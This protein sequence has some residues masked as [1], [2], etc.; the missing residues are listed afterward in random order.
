VAESPLARGRFTETL[1]HLPDVSPHAFEV[2]GVLDRQ[3]ADS[4]PFEVG[5]QTR[6]TA[7]VA[8]YDVRT[9]R[10]YALGRGPAFRQALR[11]SLQVGV[12]VT[13]P[14]REPDNVGPRRHGKHILVCALIERN[15]ARTSQRRIGQ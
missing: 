11:F 6:V 3:H 13:R 14:G 9:G 4:A 2:G 12:G 8:D 7:P 15:D 10:Q 1:G 5:H